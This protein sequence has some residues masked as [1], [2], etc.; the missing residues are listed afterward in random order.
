VNEATA[1]LIITATGALI[2]WICAQWK[3]GTCGLEKL[4]LL[5]VNFVGAVTGVY[6]FIWAVRLGATSTQYAA[7]AG[8][9]G[10]CMTFY[11]IGKIKEEFSCLF[12]RTVLPKTEPNPQD[13]ESQN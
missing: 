9:T 11:T 12:A 6:I 13:H 7:W 10:V 1:T 3:Q 8:I 4:F 5:A 2:Y